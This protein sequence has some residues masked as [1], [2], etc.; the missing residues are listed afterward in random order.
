[1]TGIAQPGAVLPIVAF[2]PSTNVP[3][4]PRFPIKSDEPLSTLSVPPEALVL[5]AAA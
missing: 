3:A 1:M 2:V 4:L 5:L